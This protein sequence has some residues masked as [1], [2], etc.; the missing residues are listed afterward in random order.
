MNKSRV[1]DLMMI[2]VEKA[3][4]QYL[5]TIVTEGKSPRYVEWLKSRLNLLL[6]R[7]TDGTRP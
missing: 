3:V 6:A 7:Q 1:K 5:A 4:D 2:S